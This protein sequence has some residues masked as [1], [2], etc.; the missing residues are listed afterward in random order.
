VTG[1]LRV[2]LLA[3]YTNVA[4]GYSVSLTA[5]IEGRTTESVWDFGDGDVAINE[6]FV[7]HSWAQP[8]D[9]LV[10]LW[11]FNES[12]EGGVSATVT[13][14]VAAQLVYYVAATSTNP[15][16]PYTSWATAASNIQGAVDATVPGA[17][18]LVTNGVYPGGVTVTNPLT[19]LSVNGPQFTA[20]NGG[21]TVQCVSLSDGASLTGFT[22]TNGYVYDWGGGVHCASPNAFLTNCVITGNSAQ[23]DGGGAFGGTLYNS[24]LTGNSARFGGGGASSSTLYNCIVYFNLG[25]NY[26]SY[27]TL[28]YCC[29]TPL[30]ANGVRNITSDPCSLITPAATCAS[31]P[32]PPALMPGTTLT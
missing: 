14:H 27:C 16:L 9:Y 18:V 28:N 19:L 13:I 11:A 26:D 12:L 10:A 7:T 1:P 3:N 20:I 21:G 30:P 8:G 22:L 25:A 17:L 31:N 24:T 15:Q 2:S 29:T 5:L 23:S 6:P 4:M 32:T